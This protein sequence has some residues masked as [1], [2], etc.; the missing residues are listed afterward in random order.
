[1][2]RCS[3][4][5]RRLYPDAT[6]TEH[7]APF[8]GPPVVYSVRMTPEDVQSIQGLTATFTPAQR[9]SRRPSTSAPSRFRHR[10]EHGRTVDAASAE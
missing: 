1:M 10:L 8:G 4:E 6:F 7:R 2:R 9:T 5:A 3:Q